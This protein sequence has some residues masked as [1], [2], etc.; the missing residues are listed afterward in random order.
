MG[1]AGSV[2]IPGMHRTFPA[3]GIIGQIFL[4]IVAK[5]LQTPFITSI[6]RILCGELLIS[7]LPLLGFTTSIIYCESM[8]GLYIHARAQTSEFLQS[9][10]R[11]LAVFVII[12]TVG[13]SQLSSFPRR[14]RQSYIENR[15]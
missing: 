8:V 1:Q 13:A 10:L 2:R 9:F 11:A 5:H 12:L 6:F 4:P 14:S 7:T 3:H 15:Q